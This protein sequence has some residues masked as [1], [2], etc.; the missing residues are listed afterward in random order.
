[1][2][3]FLELKMEYEKINN[4]EKYLKDIY[5]DSRV[6][7][8]EDVGHL[9]VKVQ[10]Q[11][12]ELQKSKGFLDRITDKIPFGKKI[13]ETANQEIKLQQSLTKFVQDTLNTFDKKYEELVKHLDLFGR[14]KKTFEIELEDLKEWIDEAESFKTSSIPEDLNLKRLII[15]AKSEVN[16][17]TDTLNSLINP[18]IISATNLIQN[19]NELT[20]ILKNILFS[21]LKTM[22]GI[23]SFKNAANM[24]TTLKTSIVEIQKLNVLNANDAIL[25][26]LENSKTNLMSKEDMEELKAIRKEGHTKILKLVDEIK[27]SQEINAIYIENE[28]NKVKQLESKMPTKSDG[29][30][31]EITHLKV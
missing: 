25:N 28:Y 27:K 6:I 26:I 19:I 18:I 22:V 16:R 30:T 21:E 11:L 31:S 4:S 12:K 29:N 9:L 15:D 7:D 23:N 13:K 24:M 1:M 5:S 17:K 2:K 8:L 20:P 3:S 10:D 14:T